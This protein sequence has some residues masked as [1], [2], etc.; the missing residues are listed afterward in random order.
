MR[1]HGF[2]RSRLPLLLP[3]VVVVPLTLPREI[4]GQEKK[5]APQIHEERQKLEELK[6]EITKE[7]K[8]AQEVTKRERTLAQE[9]AHTDQKLQEK[10]RELK[11]LEAKL[12]GSEARTAA[13]S[14]ETTAAEAAV[15]KAQAHLR[16]RL[17]AIYKQG[18]FGY[19]RAL[20]SANDIPRA[21]QRLK[22]LAAIA[23]QDAE[24]VETY[25][26]TLTNLGAKRETLGQYKAETAAS[27]ARARAARFEIIEEQRKQRILL[28]K[29]REEKEGHLTAI[30]ELELATQELQ[31]LI[32]RLQT[33]EQERRRQRS[34]GESP[35]ESAF[36]ALKGKLPWPTVG[37]VA[38]TFGRQEHPRFRTV[39][40]NNGIEITAPEGREIRAV[41]GGAVLFADWFKGYG[42]LI[43][44]DHGGGYYTL[45]A[46][47]SEILVRVGERVAARQ[48]IA[49]VGDTGSLDGPQ[50]YF[51]L[52]HRGK[53]QDPLAWLVPQ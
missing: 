31:A 14:K 29:V 46:H 25:R 39:T 51:E 26:A 36:T 2:L 18:N 40:Y 42:Q 9:L 4:S 1:T 38:S 16:R 33:E 12:K 45:Y 5:G 50:L 48:A 22:Y 24:L 3:I 35:G 34:R 52:R 37:A 30:R 27:E 7:K 49:Y 47:A 15:W 28:A 6:R 21:E 20:L 13:L 10:T 17:R 43:V 44:L 23:K 53:P 8:K 32:A 11:A 19:I 41:T